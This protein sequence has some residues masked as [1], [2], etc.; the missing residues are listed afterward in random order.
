MQYKNS[1]MRDYGSGWS[2]SHPRGNSG[3]GLRWAIIGVVSG[4]GFG[5]LGINSYDANAIRINKLTIE[6]PNIEI[7]PEVLS[8]AASGKTHRPTLSEPVSI[9]DKPAIAGKPEDEPKREIAGTWHKVTVKS[10]DS[11]AK[12]FARLGIPARQL[13]DIVA[14]GGAAK[15]LTRIY[16]GQTLQFRTSKDEGL[17]ELLYEIDDL[18][19]VSVARNE[20][21]F[22]S[23]L[24]AREPERRTISASG[25]IENSLFLAAQRAELPENVTMELAGIFGWDIDFALD[26]RRGDEFA[27]LYEDLY[28]DG[29]R[30]GTGNILA[31]EFTNNGKTFQ[32]V[33]YT[34]AKN[35]TDYYDA[36]GRSMRKTF[37]RTPVS[38]SRISSGFSLGRKHPILNRIRAHKGVDYAASRGTPVKAT[39][40]GRIVLRGKK[41]GYGNTVVIQHGSTYS[42][43]YA[44]LSR[45]ARGQK[46]G[47]R[48][49]QGQ[50]IG[51]VGSSGLATG[52]HLHYEFRVNGAHRNPL[53][54]KLP[55]AAP[56]AK[57]YQDDFSK[58]SQNLLSQLELSTTQA[59][60]LQQGD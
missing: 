31:A 36:S 5:L 6:A 30:I 38:F 3:R 45:Y 27:V 46:T 12:I 2:N 33:R 9:T 17:L 4:L 54:V 23:E 1:S 20:S 29:K 48:V 42:T 32:A 44:H 28:L 49:R 18:N 43:L 53:T 34:D 57:A 14:Q 10:G 39:G 37:L 7:T 13:H 11:L 35:H 15:K 60:A 40:N 41:G 25:T 22:A 52:P 58:A 24:T 59:V 51:Y 19:K 55:S 16:P 8:T 26:I 50:V 56:L 21:G 47:S